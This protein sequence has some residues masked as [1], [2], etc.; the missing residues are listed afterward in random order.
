MGIVGIS[1]F[2]LLFFLNSTLLQDP[3]SPFIQNE[4]E[5]AVKQYSVE[6]IS[7][8]IDYSG[9]KTNEIFE[10]INHTLIIIPKIR[11]S[12]LLKNVKIW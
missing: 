10:N 7:L 9:V 5:R 12:G 11:I 1:C 6:N 2:S 3:N 8:F 4:E